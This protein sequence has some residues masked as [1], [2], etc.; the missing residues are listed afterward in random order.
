MFKNESY[1]HELTSLPTIIHEDVVPLFIFHYIQAMMQRPLLIWHCNRA[2]Y[3]VLLMGNH[4][5]FT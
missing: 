5:A 3:N 2:L 1:S 4:L